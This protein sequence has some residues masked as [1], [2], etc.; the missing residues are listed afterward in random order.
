MLD[1]D[2]KS[3]WELIGEVFDETYEGAQ[4][5]ELWPWVVLIVVPFLVLL[6]LIAGIGFFLSLW[7][8]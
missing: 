5:N 2:E 8:G 7:I 4:S 3:T 1:M 6:G